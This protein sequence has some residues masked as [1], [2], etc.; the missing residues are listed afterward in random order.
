MYFIVTFATTRYEC[1]QNSLNC[2]SSIIHNS[3][4]LIYFKHKHKL[5][6]QDTMCHDTN[7]LLCFIKPNVLDLTIFIEVELKEWYDVK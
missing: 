2:L 6:G 5:T 1:S 7:C 4:N 3:F